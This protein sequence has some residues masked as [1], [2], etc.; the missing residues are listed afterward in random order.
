MNKN[1]QAPDLWLL[2]CILALLAIGIVMVY[3]AGSVLAFHDYGDK[4]YFVKRQLFL[5]VWGLLPCTS[6][7]GPTI[8]FGRNTASL[9]CWSAFYAD[10]RT[11]SRDRRCSRRSQKLARHQ[12]VRNSTL[13][14]YEAGHDSVSITLAQ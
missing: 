6:H 9:H 1:R 10:Y 2:I 5:P 7:R 3:S 4:F 14:V 13:R 12:L 8:G 11:Y